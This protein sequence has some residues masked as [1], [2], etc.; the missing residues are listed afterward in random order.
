MVGWQARAAFDCDWKTSKYPKYYTAPGTPR[1]NILYNF[2]NAK[3]YKSIVVTEG[4]TDVWRIGPQAVCTLGA[5]MSAAQ[6]Q[7]ILSLIHI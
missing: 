2:G 5:S 6:T 7:L 3:N 4:V 1:K